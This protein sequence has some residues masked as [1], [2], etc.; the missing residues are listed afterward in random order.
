MAKAT[1]Y[2]WT[3]LPETELTA[4]IKRRL[5]TGEKA[6]L[7]ELDFLKGTVISKHKHPH[8]QITYILSGALEFEVHGEKRVIRE[9]EVVVVLQMCPMQCSPWRTRSHSM[10]LALPAKIF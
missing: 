1:F 10:S 6:M 9:R 5:I 4:Q 8:E 2:R 7:V 3:D